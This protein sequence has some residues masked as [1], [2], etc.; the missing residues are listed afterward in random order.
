MGKCRKMETLKSAKNGNL[1]K[2]ENGKMEKWKNRFFP[3][4]EKP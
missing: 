4:R 1:E 3:K 2:W